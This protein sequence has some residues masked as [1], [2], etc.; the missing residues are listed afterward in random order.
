MTRSII[1]TGASKGIGRA[2]A[3]ALVVSGWAVIGVARHK[4]DADAHEAFYAKHDMTPTIAEQNK[5]LV[6]RAFDT[7]FNKRDYEA[8][9]SF[10]SENYIQ[11]SSRIEPGRDGLVTTAF[12]ASG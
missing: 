1:I 3:D 12:S 5:A 2:A 8:A 11:H 9:A 4:P 6:L 10:W 7:R